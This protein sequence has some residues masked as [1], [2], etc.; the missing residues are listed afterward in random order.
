MSEIGSLGLQ[1]LA[2]VTV[3]GFYS[4]PSPLLMLL[5]VYGYSCSYCSCSTRVE[6]EE[7]IATT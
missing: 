3:V 5:L 4:V 7:E 6:K 2:V 1:K